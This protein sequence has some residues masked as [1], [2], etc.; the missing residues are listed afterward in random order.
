MAGVV[1]MTADRVREIE[2][3]LK[4]LK[5]T[6]RR[7]IAQ[8]IADARSHGDLSENAE[9]DAAKEEQGLHELKIS[10][11]ETQLARAEII[12]PED[13]PSDKVYI[14][15]KVKIKNLKNNAIM[16]YTMVSDEEADFERR[17]LSVTSPIGK[18]LM[19]KVIGDKVEINAPA[20]KMMFEILD[21][22][23]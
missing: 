17:K 23:K 20:G 19:G 14:L 12:K 13:L 6:G 8:K 10:K 5:G 1:Y 21:I 9:Y 4:I 15:T 2:E 22:G 18:A 16:D 3:E 7:A 11:L